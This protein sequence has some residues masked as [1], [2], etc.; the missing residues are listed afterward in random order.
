MKKMPKTIADYI[1]ALPKDIRSRFIQVRQTIKAAAPQSIESIKWG[2]P[3]FSYQR[4]LVVY[5][6]HKNHIG[7][8][9]S[10]SAIRIHSVPP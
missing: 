9:P 8:Y 6:A 3:A 2:M 1:G 10:P 5:A 4:V 7:L